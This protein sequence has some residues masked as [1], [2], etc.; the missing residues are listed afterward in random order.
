MADF[1]EKIGRKREDAII[2]LI[3][4][5]SIEEAARAC[6]TPA[7]TLYRWLKEPEFEAAYRDARRQAY[8]QSISRL[9]QGSAAAATTLL[10]VMVDPAT[11]PSTRVRAAEAVLSHAAKA[12]EIEDIEVRVTELE[13]AARDSQS[14]F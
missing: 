9:Q 8:G 12:I 1:I 14:R 2:A 4:Q 3:S 6:N 10:K 7:R 11:P 13:K 5:R